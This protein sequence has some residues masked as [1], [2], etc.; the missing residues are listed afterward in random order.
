MFDDGNNV[1]IYLVR[2]E[3]ENCTIY[4]KLKIFYK[5]N[6]YEYTP[7]LYMIKISDTHLN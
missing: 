6:M 1:C 3:L 7:R 4:I 5:G 2:A